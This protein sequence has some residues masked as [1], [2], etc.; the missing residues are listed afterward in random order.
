MDRVYLHESFDP[1]YP[2]MAIREL[3]YRPLVRTQ[4]CALNHI[5]AR[6]GLRWRWIFRPLQIVDAALLVELRYIL[7]A[8]NA[9][10]HKGK[11]EHV[12]QLLGCNFFV[13]S[14]YFQDQ[15]S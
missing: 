2:R 3:L 14:F 1:V 15:L 13:H 7:T 9:R 6:E 8:L 12:F 11:R 4:F 10:A 5:Y